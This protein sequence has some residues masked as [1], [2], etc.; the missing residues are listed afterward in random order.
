LAYGLLIPHLGLYWDDLPYA[1]IQHRFGPEGYPAFVSSD[2]PYSA[3]VFMGL[4]WLLGEQLLGYHIA[5]LLLHWLCGLLLWQLVRT[6]WPHH[7]LEAMCTGLLF[8]I[9]PGFLGHPQTITY[10]HHFLAMTLYLF[11][12]IATVKAVKGN[13]HKD[14][15]Q[16]AWLWHVPSVLATGLS[17]FTIEYFLGW[18]AVRMVIV[19][20][21][22]FQGSTNL[23][24]K[25]GNS[26]LHLTPYWLM[27]LCFLVWRVLIFRFPTYHPLD[28]GVLSFTAL[29]WWIDIF[30]QVIEAVF[31]VWIYAPIQSISYAVSQPG[32]FAYLL[33][34]LFSTIF[35]FLYLH[36]ILQQP[37][38]NSLPAEMPTKNK[39]AVSALLVA[40]AGIAFAGWPFWLVNLPLDI[41]D[42]FRSRFTLA[43][44]P[45]VALLTTILFH[46]MAKIRNR[47]GSVLRSG[48]IAILVGSSIGFHYWNTTFYRSQW[49]EVQSYFQQLIHRVP[50]LEKGTVLLVNDMRS[51]ILYQDDSLTALLN[52]T[53]APDNL[54]EDLDFAVF[55]LS[56][57]L[58]SSLPDL[59]PGLP[60]SHDYRSL[61]FSGSTD[62][63]LV[64]YYEPPG[65]LRVLD[66]NQPDRI[67]QTLPEAMVPAVP[68]SN[69]ATI[70]TD[71]EPASPPSH[72]F[73]LQES[74]NWCLFFQDA[75]LAAQKGDWQHVAEI[76]D[77]ALAEEG[78][79]N[80]LTEYF[81]FIEGYLRTGQLSQAFKISESMSERTQGAFNDRICRLWQVV[82]KDDPHHFDNNLEA[83]SM[84]GQI[85]SVD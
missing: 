51:I 3:W 52:W 48:L 31:I 49:L 61:K 4:T 84:I 7:E 17:Q 5:G 36:Y 70:V 22:I 64:T 12:L 1:L 69:L 26:I 68:L 11:S 83:Q 20:L 58:G 16:N 59:E 57:R 15:K 30:S 53:Y 13:H 50:G 47:F 19:L 65:C 67:P 79:A 10:S 60:I 71:Q 24:K 35:V 54:T 74:D 72:L 66:P 8:I 56:V 42:P 41:T 18:E 81:V 76:G 6:I 80:D 21:I 33:L 34:T 73:T 82:Q 28:E 78:Q 2:R 85:C 14:H 29:S 38:D 40:V 77:R 75:E 43:F 44:I 62:H 9:F 63:I 45:W 39:F 25:V 32:W 46:L 27:T 55:Y 23:E 37:A